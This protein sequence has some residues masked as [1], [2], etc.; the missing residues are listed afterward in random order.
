MF[1]VKLTS[2]QPRCDYRTI[3]KAC[4]EANGVSYE[5]SRFDEAYNGMGTTLVGGVIKSG[6][7]GYIINVGDSRAYLISPRQRIR[8]ITRDHSLWRNWWRPAA[9]TA[10]QARRTRRRT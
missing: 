3:L 10:E 9:I 1:T 5:Y 7:N 8:Q 6:G 4:A 2:R